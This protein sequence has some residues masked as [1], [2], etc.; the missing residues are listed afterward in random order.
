MLFILLVSCK[1][2]PEQTEDFELCVSE[3]T[4]LIPAYLVAPTSEEVSYIANYWKDGSLMEWPKSSVDDMF[5]AGSKPGESP[6]FLY[7]KSQGFKY[8]E[9]GNNSLAFELKPVIK[10]TK[11][12]FILSNSY[13]G[14]HVILEWDGFNQGMKDILHQDTIQIQVTSKGK[15]ICKPGLSKEEKGT[16]ICKSIVPPEITVTPNPKDYRI[17]ILAKSDIVSC[18][19]FS[20]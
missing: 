3:A 20:S 5:R 12:N 1:P 11:I 4:K 19:G 18:E 10:E 9:V 15:N 13:N 14:T 2:S 16:Y 7:L 6:E 17:F 8:Q